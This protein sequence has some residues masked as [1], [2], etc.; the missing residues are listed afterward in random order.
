MKR[1]SM[2]V[3]FAVSVIVVA[4][5]VL[6]CTLQTV[7][8][9]DPPKVLR[10]APGYMYVLGALTAYDMVTP[11]Y[12]PGRMRFLLDR[13]LRSE[14]LL[15]ASEANQ[16]SLRVD[17]RTRAIYPTG[18]VNPGGATASLYN[19]LASSVQVVD[20]ENGEVIASAR[21]SAFNGYG[22]TTTDFTEREHAGDIGDFLVSIVR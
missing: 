15:A 7:Q 11:P 21:F 9:T 5:S 3:L 1:T 19:E 16:K 4:L 13:R 22:E 8:L 20:L 2:K 6:S 17:V 18:M 10:K 14:G 12:L